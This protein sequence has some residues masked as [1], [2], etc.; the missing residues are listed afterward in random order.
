MFFSK[1]DF[2]L[3]TLY[4]KTILFSQLAFLTLG[5]KKRTSVWGSCVV[6]GAGV[7][8][9]ILGSAFRFWGA[10]SHLSRAHHTAA[11]LESTE[12]AAALVTVVLSGIRGVKTL[13]TIVA[14]FQ[15]AMIS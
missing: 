10:A 4:K 2:P 12:T 11:A 5:L 14:A 9:I 8:R 13:S 7:V 3:Q 15:N 1:W 6:V